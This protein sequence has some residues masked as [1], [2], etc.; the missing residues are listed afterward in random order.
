MSE[1]LNVDA[2]ILA[3]AAKFKQHDMREH[4]RLLRGYYTARRERKRARI[5]GPSA[6][7]WDEDMLL[8][9]AALWRIPPFDRVYEL[10]A[11]RSPCG[12]GK[13]Q[14]VSPHAGL[15]TNAVFPGGRVVFCG[16]CQRRWMELDEAALP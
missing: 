7:P 8:Q 5:H 15:Y 2:L 12:C 3:V 16:M 13:V 14:G 4:L 6:P 1:E 9:W 10:R 11:A